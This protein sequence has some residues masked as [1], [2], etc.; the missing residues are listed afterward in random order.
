MINFKP[1]SQNRYFQGYFNR[2]PFTIFDLH[3]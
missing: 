2:V 3:N 1:K